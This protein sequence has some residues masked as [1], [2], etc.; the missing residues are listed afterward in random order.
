MK[1]EFGIVWGFVIAFLWLVIRLLSLGAIFSSLGIYPLIIPVI[2]EAAGYFLT[3]RILRRRRWPEESNVSAYAGKWIAISI[4]LL[5]AFCVLIVCFCLFF[6]FLPLLVA[7][8]TLLGCITTTRMLFRYLQQ[9][10]R[11]LS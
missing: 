10:P 9:S 7:P 1:M 3:L 11:F 8:P 4:Q 5:S 2:G 6:V